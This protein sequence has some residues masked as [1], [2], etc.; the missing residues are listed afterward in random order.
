MSVKE[1]D[2]LLDNLRLLARFQ[3]TRSAAGPLLRDSPI[4]IAPWAVAVERRGPGIVIPAD[5]AVPHSI[6]DVWTVPFNGTNVTLWNRLPL[7]GSTWQAIPDETRPLWWR[8]PSGTLLPAWNVWANLTDLLTFRDDREIAQRDG[9]G[10]LPVEQT[11]RFRRRLLEVPAVNEANAVILDALLSTAAGEIPRLQLPGDSI[12]PVSVVLSHDCDQLRG[13]DFYTQAIRGYRMAQSIASARGRAAI[14]HA[15]GLVENMLRPRR[16]FLGNMLGMIDLER[17]FGF[18][19]VVYILN[20]MG[21]RFGARSGSKIAEEFVRMV[22]A[23]WEVGIHYNYDTFG[24]HTRFGAQKAEI[25][26][27]T[28]SELIAGRAHYLRFDPPRSP[29]FVAEHGIRY[30]ESVGWAHLLA[31]RAGIA[32]PFRPLDPTTGRALDLVEVP[33]VFMDT[34]LVERRK[35]GAFQRMYVHLGQ[36]GGMATVLIHP[37]AFENPEVPG[38]DGLY[39]DVLREAYR[40]GARSWTPSEVLDAA[41]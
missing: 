33:L 18:R 40:N 26:G 41:R 34:P 13:N 36:I 2:W 6:D 21:G 19:S 32:G 29:A 11:P 37:G 1:D 3:F 4:D 25:E 38:G 5:I 24:D 20:G 23:E 35:D 16:Y 8:H 14:R 27:F 28:G 7:P 30:D 15:R 12:A 39:F 31:Y 9:H 17:Q 10:R 22:P